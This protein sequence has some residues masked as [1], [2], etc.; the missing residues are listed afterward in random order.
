MREYECESCGFT[1]ELIKTFPIQC[2]ECM[3]H[4][5][6]RKVSIPAW[7]RPGKYG[8]GGGL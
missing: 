5:I 6:K 4:E 2:P 8:K 7:T 1:W 3:S